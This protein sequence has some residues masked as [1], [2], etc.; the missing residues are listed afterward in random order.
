MPSC[1]SSA[2][3]YLGNASSPD[4][5]A[6]PLCPA[7]PPEQQRGPSVSASA[8]AKLRWLAQHWLEPMRGERAM[9]PAAVLSAVGHEGQDRPRV[10][11]DPS[12][13]HDHCVGCTGWARAV[14][15]S[16]RDRA[17]HLQVPPSNPLFGFI[18]FAG[19]GLDLP[20]P[21]TGD[22][23]YWHWHGASL[24]A[25]LLVVLR[26]LQLAL[27]RGRSW[28]DFDLR[29]SLDDTCHGRLDGRPQPLL[30]MVA[31]PSAPTL[32][33]V[34]W[35]PLGGREVELAAWDE[36]LSRREALRATLDARWACRRPVALFR[37]EAHSE[38]GVVAVQRGGGVRFERIPAGLKCRPPCLT[39][40]P[41]LP[42]WTF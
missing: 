40:A 10:P 26:L 35:N 11:S 19:C 8:A 30:S 38:Y 2:E 9:T 22:E 14:T 4:H 33:I 17:I 6:G 1:L 20:G 39:T 18:S 12:A 5:V 34:Q 27:S 28:P 16:V 3:L 23:T 31:C 21:T 15:I 32:P 42:P 36:V 25:R 29:L 13:G 7:W 24:N 41:H 37:G